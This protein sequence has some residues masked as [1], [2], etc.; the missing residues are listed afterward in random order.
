MLQ[1]KKQ[2]EQ[3][4]ESKSPKKY[5]TIE[6]LNKSD[7]FNSNLQIPIEEK[8]NV[9]TM[10]EKQQQGLENAKKRVKDKISEEKGLTYIDTDKFDQ[11]YEERRQWEERQ[12]GSLQQQTKERIR[13]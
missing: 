9:L 3:Q 12:V 7:G 13:E 10:K 8:E 5:A 6:E 1:K 11:E 2:R 4:H